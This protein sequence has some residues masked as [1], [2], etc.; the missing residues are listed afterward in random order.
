M[1]RRRNR[2]A[3]SA[4]PTARA[5]PR[6]RRSSDRRCR[7]RRRARRIRVRRGAGDLESSGNLSYSRPSCPHVR[8]S[9]PSQRAVRAYWDTH[10][11]DLDI[12]THPPGSPGFFADLEQYHFEKLH[13]LPRLVPF[14]QYP[15][16]PRARGR[17][18]GRHRPGSLRAAWRR[19]SPASTSRRPRSRSRPRISRIEKLPAAAARR[20]WRGAAVRRSIVRSRLRAWC[21]AIHDG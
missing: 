1:W 15:R 17:M 11:H 3:R 18:R 12:T 8:I 16:A 5:A 10:I 20:R 21:R 4:Q 13:H 2:R 14:E 7:R 19:T 9:L 6:R